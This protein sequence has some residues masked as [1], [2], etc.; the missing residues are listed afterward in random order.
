MGVNNEL[1]EGYAWRVISPMY[2]SP[3]A[4]RHQHVENNSKAAV[5]WSN[6]RRINFSHFYTYNLEKEDEVICAAS[7]RYLFPVSVNSLC[8]L[9]PTSPALHHYHQVIKNNIFIDMFLHKLHR[10]RGPRIAVMPFIATAE[11]HRGQ[12]FCGMLLA[13]VESVIGSLC[14]LIFPWISFQ[15]SSN[16]WRFIQSLAFIPIAFLLYFPAKIDILQPSSMHFQVFLLSTVTDI[17][18][19]K[20]KRLINFLGNNNQRRL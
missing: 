5:A 15:P 7:I 20:L 3:S 9:T 16:M 10:I 18:V 6:L 13:I 17:Y 8:D 11:N 14:H 1:D 12:G 4:A 2:M 19:V